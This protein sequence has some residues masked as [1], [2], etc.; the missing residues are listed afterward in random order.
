MAEA[1]PM[2]CFRILPSVFLVLLSVAYGATDVH[3]VSAVRV[4]VHLRNTAPM[5]VTAGQTL[6][7]D[8]VPLSR[9]PRVMSAMGG[10][11]LN[12]GTVSYFG[13]T[14]NKGIQIERGN[15]DF[16]VIAPLGVKIGDS[17]SPQG[18]ASL[19]AWL[20]VPV[21]PYQVYLDNV[22]LTLQPAAIGTATAMGITRHALK[23]VVPRN[24]NGTNADFKATIGF[25]ITEN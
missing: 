9:G 8:F 24:A 11:V 20:S 25:E 13:G 10:G 5:Q 1:M 16:S 17:S 14:S 22:P 21:V 18:T 3:P 12:I 15:E 2:K 6:S 7:F 23:I 19:K 4:G